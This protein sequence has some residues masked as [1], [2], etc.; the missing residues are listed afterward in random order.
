[1]FTVSHFVSAEL[2]VDVIAIYVVCTV[3]TKINALKKVF[4]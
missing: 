3:C 1:M 4:G 2:L